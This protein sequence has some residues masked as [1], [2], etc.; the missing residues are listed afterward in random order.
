[1]SPPKKSSENKDYCKRYREKNRA[2][3]RKND[4]KKKRAQHQKVKLLNPELYELKKKEERERKQL[5]ILRQ[6]LGLSF[7]LYQNH[8]LLLTTMLAILHHQHLFR[9]SKQELEVS[10]EQKK[11][12]PKA[13]GRKPKFLV[14]WQRIINFAS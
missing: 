14:L 11:R 6:K 8:L 13:Q 12:Y 2:T 1:M 5:F 9:Q 3:Y 7:L 4:A 10:E